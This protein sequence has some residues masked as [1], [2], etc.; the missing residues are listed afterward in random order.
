MCNMISSKRI[1]IHT[2]HIRRVHKSNTID[3][4][5]VQSDLWKTYTYIVLTRSENTV[6]FRVFMGWTQKVHNFILVLIHT[7]TYKVC[8]GN[9][10][11]TNCNVSC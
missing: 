2:I 3:W 1:S 6:H 9:V 5:G 10:I 8:L 4:N 11:S 7:N